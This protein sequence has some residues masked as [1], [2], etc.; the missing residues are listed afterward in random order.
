MRELILQSLSSPI[1]SRDLVD[2]A[3]TR[4]NL[5]RVKSYLNPRSLALRKRSP[6]ERDMVTEVRII[7]LVG[8]H[9]ILEGRG[10][11]VFP[12]IRSDLVESKYWGL[13]YWVLTGSPL[14]HPISLSSLRRSK[15]LARWL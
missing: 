13:G 9:R 7:N 8:M 4:M 3:D 10:V 11:Y 1:E 14:P 6:F 2:P 12:T 5:A 15:I